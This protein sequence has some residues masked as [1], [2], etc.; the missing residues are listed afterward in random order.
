VERLDR[1]TGAVTARV[2]LPAM[3]GATI[4]PLDGSVLIV[5]LHSTGARL[6]W[7]EAST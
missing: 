7:V 5:S 4:V 2:P 6:T 3:F 1:E